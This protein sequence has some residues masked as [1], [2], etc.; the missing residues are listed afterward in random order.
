[1]TMWSDDT[2]AK[3][4]EKGESRLNNHKR[5]KY[6]HSVTSNFPKPKERV[7]RMIFS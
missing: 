5:R 6:I 2:E 4:G 1:M 7:A 3:D